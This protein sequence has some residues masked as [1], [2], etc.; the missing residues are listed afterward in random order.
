M[1]TGN[2]I[3]P[4]RIT[5]S[6]IQKLYRIPVSEWHKDI[7]IMFVDECHHVNSLKGTYA[8]VLRA[9]PAPM[10]LGFTATLPYVPEGIMSLEGHLG[11]TIGKVEMDT[12]IAEG[13]LAKPKIKIIKVP[14]NHAVHELTRFAEVYE[15]GIT[16]NRIRNRLILKEAQSLKETGLTTLIIVRIVEHGQN[17]EKMAKVMFPELKLRFIYGDT[18]KFVREEVKDVLTKKELD[19]VVSS[20][21]WKEGITI[22]NLG[23]VIN[24][25]GGKE[26]IFPKQA[27]GRGLGVVEGKTEVVLVDFFDNSHRFLVEHFGHRLCLYFEEG[28]M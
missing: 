9:I 13:V 16:S 27:L 15:Q 11:P 25:A 5:F 14:Y 1:I 18:D 24:A 26:D 3:Q 2:V 12:L 17:L 7:D 6:N 8:K 28:W 20:V 19:V 23:A 10:R 4:S 21:I 22:Q